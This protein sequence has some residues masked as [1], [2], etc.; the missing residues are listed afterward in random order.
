ML[1]P[2]ARLLFAGVDS[3]EDAAL[4]LSSLGMGTYLGASDADTDEAV[5]S[6]VLKVRSNATANATA[7]KHSTASWRAGSCASFGNRK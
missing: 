5:T 1:T 4:T 7:W 2:A 3:A 6:A